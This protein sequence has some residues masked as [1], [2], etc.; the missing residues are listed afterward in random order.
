LRNNEGRE[1]I[2][3]YKYTDRD[4]DTLRLERN[5]SPICANGFY[6]HATNTADDRFVTIRIEDDDAPAV[7]LAILEA[8]GK[9][10]SDAEWYEGQA[11]ANLKEHVRLRDAAHARE[12]ED[13]KVQAFRDTFHEA[14]DEPMEVM[15][16]GAMDERLK[17]SW[18]KR[19]RAITEHLGV[20]EA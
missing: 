17:E 14:V 3:A 11:V 9:G 16:W 7:A 13:T 18:R 1:A 20:T 19:Y 8:A 5:G 4:G 12:V 6:V 15:D 2:V 10:G